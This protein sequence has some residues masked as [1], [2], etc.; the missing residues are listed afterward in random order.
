MVIGVATFRLNYFGKYFEDHADS[1]SLDPNE[2]LPLWL[3]AESTVDAEVNYNINEMFNVA[4]GASNLF[5]EYPDENKYAEVL[6]AQYPTT[7]V[8]GFNGGFYY[9][10]LTYT[11]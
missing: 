6:G 10:R 8:M 7:A 2:G 11:F 1:G 4:V 3:P 5:D 9:A